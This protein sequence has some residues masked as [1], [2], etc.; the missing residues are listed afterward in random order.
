MP[1]KCAPQY[2]KI[3]DNVQVRFAVC[4]GLMWR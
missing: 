2:Y 1:G 3:T 4:I